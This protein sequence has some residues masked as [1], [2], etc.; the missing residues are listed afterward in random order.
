MIR[1]RS[2]SLVD[3]FVLFGFLLLFLP[4]IEVASKS[5]GKTDDYVFLGLMKTN[6]FS[7]ASG[8]KYF[9]IQEWT[10][11]RFATNFFLAF[12]FDKDSNI[13][14]L[15]VIRMC[16]L[17]VFFSAAVFN[18]FVIVKLTK[19]RFTAFILSTILV[20]VPGFQSFIT[21][22][23]AGSYI[24]G[25]LLGLLISY[26]LVSLQTFSIRN[27]ILVVTLLFALS[28]IYQPLVFLPL[29]YPCVKVIIDKFSRDSSQRLFQVYLF[30]LLA[31]AIN[32]MIVR[33]TFSDS[34]AS[35]TLDLRT[36][37]QVLYENVL[38]LVQYPW[39]NLLKLDDY[40]LH[41]LLLF[42]LFLQIYHFW[43]LLRQGKLPQAKAFSMSQ[44][45]AIIF[46]LSGGVP[47]SFLWFF[48]ISE[49]ALDFRRY[50][51]AT[52]LFA[53]ILISCTHV[54]LISNLKSVI[55][56]SVVRST[57]TLFVVIA[58]G[59]STLTSLETSNILARE[60]NDFV[61]ASREVKLEEYA[62]ISSDE[63][64]KIYQG[65]RAVSEDF[66][67]SSLSFPNPPSFMLWLSQIEAGQ[68]IDFPPWNMNLVRDVQ[69]QQMTESDAMW[70]NALIS[71]S[72]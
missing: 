4:L 56:K 64:L 24:L 70:A 1:N 9:S 42:T 39:F 50:S 59:I 61:C 62:Q 46:V 16:V 47:L 10:A 52:I 53:F 12:V 3:R 60:W 19:S 7:L 21:L 58:Y 55:V 20:A 69:P 65:D 68:N 14:N 30:S 23:A 8:F 51:S 29:I 41:I 37:F 31:L 17:I 57:L 71:C 15:A 35:F 13:S 26:L 33:F 11:G 48:F 34:R 45:F 49:N 36:K 54:S 66:R 40:V 18:Y 22:V 67:T 72:K 63:I 38:V 25:I 27:F 32:W 6:E 5:Y 2:F 44:C 28:T 43:K